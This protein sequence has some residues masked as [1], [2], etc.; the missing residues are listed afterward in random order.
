MD[1]RRRAAFLLVLVAAS[2]GWMA[3]AQEPHRFGERIALGS[4]AS[5]IVTRRDAD[6]F[7]SAYASEFP[8]TIQ[9]LV[10]FE[11][12]SEGNG[13]ATY[14]FWTDRA[15][16]AGSDVVVLCD[17]ERINIL[18]MGSGTFSDPKAHRFGSPG[19]FEIKGRWGAVA[20]FGS[21][22]TLFFFSLPVGC[23]QERIRLSVVL[24]VSQGGKKANHQ[25]IVSE[26]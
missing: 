16:P 7:R 2:R 18:K 17:S 5:L 10:A 11:F 23:A 12:R 9:N 4:E 22:P 24:E 21:V 8:P 1:F 19:A 6:E 3:D 13:T 25:L 20:A 15:N 14:T 26:R